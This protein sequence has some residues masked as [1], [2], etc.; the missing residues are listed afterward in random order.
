MSPIAIICFIAL[1]LLLLSFLQK[2]TDI[3]SPGRLFTVIWLLAIGL[4]ELKLSRFQYS[5]TVYSWFALLIPVLSFLLGIFIVYVI[6]HNNKFDGIIGIRKSFSNSQINIQTLYSIIVALFILYS[7]SYSIT[8]MIRGFVP[9]FTKMPEVARTRWGVF[10]YGVF[11]LSVP[12]ILYLSLLYLFLVRKNLYK[13]IFIAFV[14]LLAVVTYSFLLN[15]F[16][17]ILPIILLI[18][19]LYYKTD[20]LRPKNVIILLT[21]FCL[22]FFGISSIRLSRYAINILYYLSDMKYSIDYAIFTEPYMYVTMNLENYAK[23]VQ[24]LDEFTYGYFSA[25]FILFP[26]G[27]KKELMEYMRIVDFPNIITSAYNTYTMF[28]IYYRDFG[29]FGVFFLP[30]LL[31]GVIASFYYRMRKQPNITSISL[32]G[33]CVF[34]IIFSFF[35]PIVHWIHFVFNIGLIYL[36][37]MIITKK[38]NVRDNTFGNTTK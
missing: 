20:K 27:L 23:A 24:K 12:T 26:L 29:L 22:I 14:L 1:I 28:F 17:L 33:L 8:Y 16:Y 5:W 25:D 30:V 10:G 6:N 9:M 18:V 34:V 35:V 32:Y 15:R 37:T 11:V 4:A 31:G 38:D 7:I 2:G 21:I 36:T 13:K 19:T 3:F